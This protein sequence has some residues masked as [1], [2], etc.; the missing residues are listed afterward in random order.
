MTTF[1][2]ESTYRIPIYRCVSA[3]KRDPVSGVIGVQSGPP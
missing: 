2:I 3:W 1:T